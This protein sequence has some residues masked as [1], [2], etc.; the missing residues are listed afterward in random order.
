MLVNGEKDKKVVLENSISLMAVLTVDTLKM[1]SQG[2]KVGFF[3]LMVM[4]MLA[5][6]K[7]I[8][9]TVMELIIQ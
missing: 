3:I 6:G 2:D 5:S 7:M 8:K 1:V 4:F 9:L